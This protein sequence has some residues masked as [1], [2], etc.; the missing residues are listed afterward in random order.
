MLAGADCAVV[1]SPVPSELVVLANCPAA[2]TPHPLSVT[3]MDAA[4]II[5][6][7]PVPDFFGADRL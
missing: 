6:L 3:P 5:I 2:S 7:I 4:N 1:G